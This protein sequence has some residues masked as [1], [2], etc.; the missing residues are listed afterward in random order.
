MQN[1]KTLKIRLI[2]IPNLIT[3]FNLVAGCIAIFT[4]FSY[5]Y[6][7]YSPYFILLAAVFDFFDGFAA[8][9][10]KSFSE[11]GKELDSLADVVSFGVAPGLL[12]V[13]MLRLHL[14]NDPFGY[15]ASAI[16]WAIIS[17]PLLLP[18]CAALRLA[19]FNIDERQHLSFIGLP[20]PA[21]A[22]LIA[23]LVIIAMNIPE[24]FNRIYSSPWTL[25]SLVIISS[26][27]NISEIP[28]FS[29]KFTSFTW[30]HNEIRYIFLFIAL[31]G[32]VFLHFMAIAPLIVLYI[33]VS[34]LVSRFKSN[35]V[36][37]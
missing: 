35:T 29:F 33:I 4:A 3:S 30:K 10:L 23:G 28:M 13:Q 5:E 25:N 20:T 11:V 26:L 19:K 15:P 31:I 1:D 8:R 34:I 22:Y 6:F 32:I 2:T 36:Q 37:E 27:L 17:I 24:P 7:Y 9:L 21:S 14:F 16:E 12:A 18:I